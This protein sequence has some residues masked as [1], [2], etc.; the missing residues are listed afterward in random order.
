MVELVRFFHIHRSTIAKHLLARGVV[1]RD[2]TMTERQIDEA[3]RLYESGLS[4][5]KIGAKLGFNP[6][7]ITTHVRKRGVTIRGPHER[8]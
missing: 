6:S 5:M 4:F 2:P 1:L 3:V 7:T 8:L